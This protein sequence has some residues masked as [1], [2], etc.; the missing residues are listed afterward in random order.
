VIPVLS[1]GAT[2]LSLNFSVALEGQLLPGASEGAP[3][4][5]KS[6]L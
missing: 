5:V 3:V 4:T 6:S 1:L 2:R